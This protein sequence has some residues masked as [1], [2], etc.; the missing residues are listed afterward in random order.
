MLLDNYSLYTLIAFF[1]LCSAA[2]IYFSRGK[3]TSLDYF[4]ANR[5]YPWYIVGFIAFLS[6]ASNNSI[7]SFSSRTSFLGLVAFNA[8]LTGIIAC[9]VLSLVFG[10]IYQKNNF[11][12][13]SQFIEARF[14]P[15][16]S[17]ITSLLLIF[18]CIASRISAIL[19]CA[20]AMINYFFGFDMYTTSIVMIIFCGVYSIVGGQRT[21]IMTGI[22]MGFFV[23][24]GT[25]LLTFFVSTHYSPGTTV[26]PND[27]FKLLRPYSSEE[28]FSWIGVLVALPILGVW[29]HCINQML[30]QN[31]L[32]S[33]NEQ[34]FQAGALFHGYLKLLLFPMAVLPGIMAFQLCNNSTELLLYPTLI[35]TYVPVAWQGLIISGIMGAAM[36]ALSAS[37]NAC[38]TLFTFDFYKKLYPNATDFVLMNIG[39]IATI[40]IAIISMIW[41]VLLKAMYE[42]V[43]QMITSA[44]SYF[45]PP[46]V[47]VYLLGILWKRATPKAAVWTLA[48]GFIIG[49]TKFS[50][51]IPSVDFWGGNETMIFISK[52]GRYN[53][54]VLFFFFT[55]ALMIGLSYLEPAQPIEKIKPYLLRYNWPKADAFQKR[56]Y[57]A[58]ILLVG[59]ISGIYGVWH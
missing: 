31:F 56:I 39:K 58:A 45:T 13:T 5:N 43:S 46:L 24:T 41:M 20:S 26:Y 47:A 52:F 2:A 9:V 53:F 10:R 14:N 49:I 42:N 35:H 29:Y 16:A 59:I 27:Y 17:Y 23:L 3:I 40:L 15:T 25:L 12:T 48:I 34:H 55:L 38:S 54:T 22:F 19:I 7:F 21:I 6:N 36:I 30:V 11:Y 18:M 32:S 37:F 33:K 44:L 28:Q 1:L 8:E 50:I 51:A 4:L 57:V